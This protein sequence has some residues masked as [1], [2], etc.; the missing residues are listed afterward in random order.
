MILEYSEGK[1]DGNIS[2]NEEKGN[3]A[4]KF[5]RWPGS[6]QGKLVP[7]FLGVSGK[8]D[9]DTDGLQRARGKGAGLEC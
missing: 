2:Q 4:G 5:Y 7:G 6:G 9:G 8:D 3:N 1:T